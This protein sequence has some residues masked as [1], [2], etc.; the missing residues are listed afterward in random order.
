MRRREFHQVVD[1]MHNWIEIAA[2]QQSRSAAAALINFGVLRFLA[3][4]P[5]CVSRRRS[6]NANSLWW[7]VLAQPRRI[8]T[9]SQIHSSR[10]DS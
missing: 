1:G 7:R 2:R 4:G 5:S 6:S 3:P 9:T 10:S 8:I